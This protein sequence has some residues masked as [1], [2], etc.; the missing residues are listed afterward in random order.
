MPYCAEA[1]H[2]FLKKKVKIGYSLLYF[3]GLNP[4]ENE[5]IRQMIFTKTLFIV[6]K[7]ALIFRM[8]TLYNYF[9]ISED[10]VSY[11]KMSEIPKLS[12]QYFC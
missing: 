7:I 2:D 6:L 3:F 1:T 5:D 4:I 9:W 10:E 8:V 12:M 11:L